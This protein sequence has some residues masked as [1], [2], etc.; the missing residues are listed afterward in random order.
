MIMA[1]LIVVASTL[2][3]ACSGTTRN[4]NAVK[5]DGH[6]YLLS[7]GT[8]FARK[9]RMLGAGRPFLIPIRNVNAVKFG[10]SVRIRN[11]AK[12]IAGAREAARYEATIYCIEQFG[13]SDIIWSIGP[14]DEAISLSNGSLTLAGRCDPE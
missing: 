13:T 9:Q 8:R 3:A 2:V 11:A 1:Q 4:V 10:F 12:S 7:R 5:F 6:Y 14:D